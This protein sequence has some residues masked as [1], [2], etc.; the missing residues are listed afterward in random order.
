MKKL[1]IVLGVLV[2]LGGIGAALLVGNLGGIIKGVVEKVGSQ[3]TQTPVTLAEVDISLTDG[4]G[5]LKNLV[6]ANPE[7]F[8]SE[9]AMSLGIIRVQIDPATIGSNPVVIK[10]VVID[11]PQIIYEV[12]GG[13]TNI[14]AIQENVDAFAKGLGAGGETPAGDEPPAEGEGTK[15][16]IENL[17]VRGAK[18]SVSATFLGGESVGVTVPEIHLTDLGKDD[19]G[20]SAGEVAAELLDAIAEAVIDAVASENIKGLSDAL[21][22]QGEGLIDKAGDALGGLFGG[23]DDDDDDKKKKRKN[24]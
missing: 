7:P 11:S 15:V 3:A 10:E 4:S 8:K 1:L 9:H 22:E 19:G 6:V 18:A 12:S 20:A 13:G 21:K 16:I 14:G 5:E 2:V 17:Y 23:D 24:K